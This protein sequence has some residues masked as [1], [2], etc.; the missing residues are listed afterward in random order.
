MLAVSVTQIEDLCWNMFYKRNYQAAILTGLA[1]C[2]LTVSNDS[3][4]W[5]LSIDHLLLFFKAAIWAP[6]IV[7]KINIEFIRY[8]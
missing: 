2:R 3:Y 7:L 4:V 1:I 6:H 8:F 5:W